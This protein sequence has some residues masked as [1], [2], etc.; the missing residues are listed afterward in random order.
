MAG[1]GR[2]MNYIKIPIRGLQTSIRWFY[3]KGIPTVCN[4]KIPNH[5]GFGKINTN[6]RKEVAKLVTNNIRRINFVRKPGLRQGNTLSSALFDVAPKNIVG[7]I[8]KN[9]KSVKIQKIN[10]KNIQ[11]NIAAYVNGIMIAAKSEAN[12]KAIEPDRRKSK[13][14][15]S[16]N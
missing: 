13:D 1:G 12:L 15:E 4:A 7:A 6:T 8:L 9:K 16:N 11:I 14:N 2:A 5:G 10:K 3:Y